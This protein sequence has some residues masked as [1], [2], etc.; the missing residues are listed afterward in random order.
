MGPP[1]FAPLNE[2]QET[3][4]HVAAQEGQAE[5]VTVLL[6]HGASLLARDFEGKTPL[7]E[8][9]SGANAD[10][11]EILLDGGAD[12]GARDFSGRTARDV[13]IVAYPPRIYLEIFWEADSR[14]KSHSEVLRQLDS[15][16][17]GLPADQVETDG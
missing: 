10:V 11:V 6:T 9:A 2:S 16:Q 12:P 1:L 17:Q 14:F 15:H 5:V 8:A 7:H 3:P 4:L 13:A